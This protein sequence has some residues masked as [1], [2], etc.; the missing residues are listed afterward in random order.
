VNEYLLSQLS[1]SLF[2]IPYFLF[3]KMKL[4]IERGKLKFIEDD[5]GIKRKDQRRSKWSLAVQAIG[6][7]GAI[8]TVI[9]GYIQYLSNSDKDTRENLIKAMQ[10]TELPAHKAFIENLKKLYSQ[11][12]PARNPSIKVKTLKAR[13]QRQRAASICP[14]RITGDSI[15]VKLEGGVIE[16]HARK[17]GERIEITVRD[18]GPGIPAEILDEIFRP[19][20]TTRASGGGLGLHIVET[21]VKQND[22]RVRAA[23]RRDRRGAE[24]II[25][26]PAA[27]AKPLRALPFHAGLTST[28]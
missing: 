20:V 24:F 12:E 11:V 23:N 17:I 2:L 15:G 8:V 19:H 6:I 10:F 26:L 21:I 22:G 13:L 5:I 7:F 16:V 1:H 3:I 9:V 25:T 4:E 28:G 27:I 18:E 14:V